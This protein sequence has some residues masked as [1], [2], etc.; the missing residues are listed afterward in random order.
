IAASRLVDDE[1]QRTLIAAAAAANVEHFV[2][3]SILGASLDHPVDFW[4][5]KARIEAVVRA[6]GMPYTILQPSAFM[7][8][9]AY[10]LIGKHVQLGK[11]VPVFGPGNNPR[12]F[13]AASDVAEVA[14]RALVD[15][16]FVGQ[17]VPV[18]GPQN[19]TSREVATVFSRVYGTPAT[20]LHVPLAVVRGMAALIAP[21]HEGVGRILRAAIVSETTDQTFDRTSSP[22]LA[23]LRSTA[24][25]AWA[26][27]AR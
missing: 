5:T 18:G 26:R 2:F 13:V 24:L 21:M 9:H 22:L 14:H 3:T 15:A 23:G 1:G 17:S 25:D 4:R 27:A 11:R 8:V 20:M 19:L 10:E 6:C 7:E 16:R 12:N